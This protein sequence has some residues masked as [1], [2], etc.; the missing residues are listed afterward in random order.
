MAQDFHLA[1]RYFDTAAEVDS[2]ARLPRDIA[3]WLMEVSESN[4]GLR[5]IAWD[6]YYFLLYT[7]Q[8]LLSV[9]FIFSI[10]Q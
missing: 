10:V 5:S 2:Q 9:F 6:E 4:E 7:S 8:I 1:K 3:L